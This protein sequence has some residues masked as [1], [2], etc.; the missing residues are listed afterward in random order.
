MAQDSKSHGIMFLSGVVI[1]TIIAAFLWLIIKLS[2]TYTVTEPFAIHYVDVPADQI[3]PNDN[4]RVEAT[5]TTTGFKLL[6]Y[7][8]KSKNQRKVVVSL[9]DINYKKAN[10]ETYSYNSRHIEEVIAYMLGTN[11][12]DV[13][14]NEENQYF[15]MSRLASKRVKII[16]QTSI[17]FERQYNYYGEPVSFPDSATIFGSI[18]EIEKIHN[19]QTEMIVKKNVNQSI[20]TKAKIA[21]N[22]DIRCDISEVQV[23]VNVEK[24]TEAEIE[25]P[26]TQPDGVILHLYP[27]K[28]KIKY[29][30][31]MKDYAIINAM[32]FK[33]TIDKDDIY[34]N[35]TLPVKLELS[36]NNT[37]ILGIDPHEVEYIVVQQ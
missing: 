9:N 30:V 21:I 31:A 18:Y 5:M 34:S 35:E 7:Y 14:L 3:I 25:I 12:S 2:D 29:I 17:M 36:P 19:L 11:T 10:F 20:E 6:R 4:Y 27:N 33:V 13:K 37:Q 22:D 23:L 15:V 26:I 32:S 28:V 24:F 8:R 1:F 16:P